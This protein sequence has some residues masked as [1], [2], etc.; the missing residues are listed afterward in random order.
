M[1]STPKICSL[2]PTTETF[3]ENVK[4]AHLQTMMWKCEDA[5]PPD[6]DPLQYG[7]Q[8]DDSMMKSP[9]PITVPSNIPHAPPNILKL[10]R[11]SCESS[12]PCKSMRCGC[13]HARLP[14]TLFCSCQGDSSCCNELTKWQ[15]IWMTNYYA[16]MQQ[17]FNCGF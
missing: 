1:T 10:I 17:D 9:Q 2:P 4:R 5:C 16:W 14:C 15:I 3:L 7:W 6:V 13:S 11:C 12:N 8:R